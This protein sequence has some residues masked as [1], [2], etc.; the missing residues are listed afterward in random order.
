MDIPSLVSI[1]PLVKCV[2]LC[3][4][5]QRRLPAVRLWWLWLITVL[6]HLLLLASNVVLP[7]SIASAGGLSDGSA[8]RLPSGS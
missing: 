3:W 6:I 5:R 7:P 2:T 8:W 1:R 4:Y